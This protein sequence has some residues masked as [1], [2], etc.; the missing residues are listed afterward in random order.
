[1]IN[2]IKFT[3][4]DILN[5]EWDRE[6]VKRFQD[7]CD[8]IMFAQPHQDPGGAALDMLF[9]LEDLARDLNE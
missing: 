5:C 3:N 7:G 2:I 1:M 6:S 4:N 8:V 9:A